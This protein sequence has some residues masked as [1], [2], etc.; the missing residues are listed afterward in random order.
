MDIHLKNLFTR[1][2]DQ[3]GSGPG[4]G[5]SSGTCLLNIEG[6]SP[7][8]IRSVF[9]ASAAFYRTDPWKRLWPSHLFAI[10]IGKDSDWSLKKQLY[11]IAH[12]VGGEGGDLGIHMFKSELDAQKTTGLRETNRVPNVEI[13]RVVFTPQ[14]LI[15]PSN[16]R[17]IHSLSLE[18]SAVDQYPIVDVAR[19][20]SGGEL[21]FRN[22]T[23]EEVRYVYAFLKA[24][25]LVH[26]LL[27]VGNNGLQR[28]GRLVSFEPFIE[29]VDAQET[30]ISSQGARVLP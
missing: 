14:S 11:P 10:R 9:S 1:F 22:P 3:F 29:T 8:F 18:S 5:P 25:A 30:S 27:Q 12:F 6:I 19:F 23:S 24:I 13:L 28:R 26:L 20:S 2:Q 15:F 7:A 16:K 17:M 4:L 21:R